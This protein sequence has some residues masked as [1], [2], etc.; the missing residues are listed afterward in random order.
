MFRKLLVRCEPSL[1]CRRINSSAQSL[2]AA[3]VGE[4]QLREAYR[5]QGHRLAD[6]D[7]LGLWK[8]ENVE[9]IKSLRPEELVLGLKLH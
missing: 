2:E 1:S 7:P 8:R 5:R 4:K 6:I 9:D 3:S